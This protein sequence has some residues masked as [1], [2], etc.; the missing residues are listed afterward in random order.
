MRLSFMGGG[1]IKISLKEE[2]G[3]VWAGSDHLRTRSSGEFCEHSYEPAG[4]INLER[5]KFREASTYVNL[6]VSVLGTA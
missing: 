1:N 4:S 5:P 6:N 3:R 2:D